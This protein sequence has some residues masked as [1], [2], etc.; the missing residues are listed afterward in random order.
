[1]MMMMMIRV[2]VAN[3]GIV[4]NEGYG[5]KLAYFKMLA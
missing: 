4:V 3:G 5:K 2:L 1:M